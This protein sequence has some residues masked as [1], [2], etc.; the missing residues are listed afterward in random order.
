M[1]S[2]DITLLPIDNPH[3]AA[4]DFGRAINPVPV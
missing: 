2:S 4:V 3:A 1:I